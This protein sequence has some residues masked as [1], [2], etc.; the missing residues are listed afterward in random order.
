ML[1]DT[2]LIVLV[3]FEAER[4]QALRTYLGQHYDILAASDAAAALACLETEAVDLLLCH[5]APQQLDAI[6]LLHQARLAYPN[7]IRVLGGHVSEADTVAAINEA[8][9]YQFFPERWSPEQIELLVRRALENREL[10]YRHRHLSR[11]LK[12]AENILQHHGA[13]LEIESGGRFDKLIYCSANMAKVCNHAKKA[14]ATD[15]PVLIQGE[16]GTGK[17]LMARGI[18]YHSQR[19]AQPLLIQNCGGMADELLLSELFGHKR[20]A[21]TGAV[22]DRL[23][24]FPAADGGTVFLDEISDVSPAFQVALLRFLQEGEVKPLGS[25]KVIL[26]NVR[27]IAASNRPLE[28]MVERGEF[29]RDLYYRLNGFNLTIPPLRDRR[30]DI[31]VL[32]EFLARRYGE[33]I[34]RRIMGLEQSL[35]D[36]LSAYHWPGNVRELENEMRR[37]VALADNGTFLTDEQ[38]SPHLARLKALP[39]R[40][41]DCSLIE[42]KTLKEKVESLEK[43]LLQEALQRHR[44]NQSKAA[45]E[46]GLSRVG[47]ANKIQR[48]SLADQV[49]LA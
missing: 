18:H 34:N 11:D 16:T 24:L 6:P 37:L 36:K 19:H 25:D 13:K 22:S 1:K 15:L 43:H 27:I 29:R 30:E 17:E 7:V 21:F 2:S 49:P 31:P 28:A 9:I 40:C 4:E 42:G 35:Q 14:A 10:A 23:G 26:C 32:A 8:A 47:L 45:A 12:F 3:G 5:H 46:L 20:G 38:L 48:Y 41:V 44:W 33:S 39:K